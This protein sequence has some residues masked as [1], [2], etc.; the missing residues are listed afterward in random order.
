ML[1]FHCI[2]H[3][4]LM[5]VNCIVISTIVNITMREYS[6]KFFTIFSISATNNKTGKTATSVNEVIDKFVEN[7]KL[8]VYQRIPGCKYVL[9]FS[10]D[11]RRDIRCIYSYADIRIIDGNNERNVGTSFSLMDTRMCIP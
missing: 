7:C 6:K 3:N 4:L 11:I 10:A 8:L 9:V 2:L 1:L 5:L